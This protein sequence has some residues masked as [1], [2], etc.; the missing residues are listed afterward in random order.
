LGLY[1]AKKD[2]DPVFY[3]FDG[4]EEFKRQYQHYKKLKSGKDN[5]S[6]ASQEVRHID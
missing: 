5:G 1:P 6:K 2:Y 4:F 3:I